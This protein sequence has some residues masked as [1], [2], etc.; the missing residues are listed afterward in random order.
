MDD[1][2]NM[3]LESIM[4]TTS[5]TAARKLN[6]RANNNS[7]NNKDKV[8]R[9]AKS[10]INKVSSPRSSS[11]GSSPRGQQREMHKIVYPVKNLISI[12][13][14]VSNAI[15][16]SMIGP[17]GAAI[18]ELMDI[19]RYLFLLCIYFPFSR[20]NTAHSLPS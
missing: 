9:S 6:N 13:F 18:K 10:N 7:R 12:K 2:L 11:R 16:G 8:A 4:M 5:K 1:F 17:G 14:L 15:S 19:T 20:G 3:S